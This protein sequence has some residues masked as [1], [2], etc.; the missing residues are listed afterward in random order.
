MLKRHRSPL[1]TPEHSLT[2][3]DG[4]GLT[5]LQLVYTSP[6]PDL[7]RSKVLLVETT[8]TPAQRG[9]RAAITSAGIVK[10]SEGIIIRSTN[11]SSSCMREGGGRKY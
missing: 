2:K 10:K 11:K 7:R 3:G 6:G 5:F 8:A 4:A 9:S 1:Q